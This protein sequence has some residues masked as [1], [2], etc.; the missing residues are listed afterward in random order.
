MKSGRLQ[1]WAPELIAREGGIQSYSIEMVEAAAEILGPDRVTVLSKSDDPKAL[2]KR[3]GAKVKTYATGNV[4]DF[5]RTPAFALM[6]VALACL[7]GPELVLSLHPH[8]S[9][10]AAWLRKWKKIPSVVTAHGVEVW[11]LPPG[12]TRK[13]LGQVD[14]ILPVSE[15]TKGRMTKEIGLPGERFQVLPNTYDDTKFFPGTTSGPLKNR[16]GL[17]G[18]K[19]LY[20]LGRLEPNERYKGFDEVLSILPQLA[21]EIPNLVYLIGGQGGDRER[22][23]AK[24]R[25]LG[26]ADRVIFAGFVPE[27]EKANY[28]RLADLFVMPGW[29]EGFGIV[30]L[31][32]AACGV[33]VLGSTLD[34][35]QEVIRAAGIGEAVNPKNAGQLKAA[36]LRMLRN[37]P[38]GPFPGLAQFDRA[39]FRNRVRDL[40]HG[41]GDLSDEKRTSS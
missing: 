33:P 36:I 35:S 5:L 21:R 39:A 2:R 9:P 4:P 1:I 24:A 34:A 11:D 19:V 18:K 29:G 27:D 14:K 30:Y 17:T 15:F 13:A 40:L 41:L 26:V 8:F 23:E 38:Q 32:S 10:V 28:Y 12:R 22:L 20:T 3:F 6:L 7:E 31:E 16:L 37:P 25:T